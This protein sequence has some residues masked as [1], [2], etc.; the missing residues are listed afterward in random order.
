[1]KL[2]Q[3]F[4]SNNGYLTLVEL[5]KRNCKKNFASLCSGRVQP[6]YRGMAVA[7][8]EYTSTDKGY[9]FLIT[10]ERKT[11]RSS[12]FTDGNNILLSF[13]SNHS[14]WHNVPP[15]E[16]SSFMTPSFYD[17][18]LH[19]YPWLI[20]PYDSVDSYAVMSTDFNYSVPDISPFT[21]LQDAIRKAQDHMIDEFDE[22]LKN[23]I[24]REELSFPRDHMYSLDDI[25]KL[26]NSVKQ[27]MDYVNK[28]EDL[29][30]FNNDELYHLQHALNDVKNALRDI[31]TEFGDD[32]WDWLENNLIPEQLGVEIFNFDQL[33]RLPASGEVWFV[34]P[35]VA[36][37]GNDPKDREDLINSEW[38]AQLC[39]DVLKS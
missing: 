28:H 31:E 9:R 16:Y 35:Y 18:K 27:L 21:R 5:L 4:E 15:R 24:S 7:A 12:T 6:L 22:E 8:S 3:L 19:G 14:S 26:S 30:S 37:T 38:L 39:Q 25:K 11:R 33:N 20:I 10:A 34:G 36:I 23:L 1:M 13:A 32:L 17:A 2:S 29:F